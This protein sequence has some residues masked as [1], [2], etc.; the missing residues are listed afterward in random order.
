MASRL[1]RSIDQPIRA[2]LSW[3]ETWEGPDQGLIS[4]WERGRQKREE[5]PEL[6]TRALKGELVILAWQG[7][8]EEK[9]KAK[10]KYGTLKYLAT[11]QGLRGED[12][13]VPLEGEHVIVCTKTGQAVIFRASIPR[14]PV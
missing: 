14:A 9:L 2:G 4:C 13:D 3:N 7:G 1:R 6:A 11:W 5:E 8:V 10:K 12:L